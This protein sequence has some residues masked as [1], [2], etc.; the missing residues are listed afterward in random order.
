M[1]TNFLQKGDYSGDQEHENTETDIHLSIRKAV[2]EYKK[3]LDE[4][5]N[6]SGSTFTASKQAKTL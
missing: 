5:S 2:F 3:V 1:I 6:P 4:G